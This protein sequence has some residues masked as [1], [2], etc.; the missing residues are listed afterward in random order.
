MIITR[1]LLLTATALSAIF[2][3]RVAVSLL[4]SEWS[5]G[6]ANRLRALIPVPASA[7]EIGR[8]YLAQ[9]PE[10]A[11]I[12]T[13]THLILSSLSPQSLDVAALDQQALTATM[14]S[15]V[16]ADFE[17]GCTAQIG[18]WILSRTEA[19]LCALCT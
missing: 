2:S 15:R 7:R 14:S 16:R 3:A 9:Y 11:G 12:D 10:E 4:S 13:L 6:A 8:I 17:Q 18:G 1:R 19:R 5:G